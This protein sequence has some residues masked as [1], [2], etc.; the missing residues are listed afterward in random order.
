MA[1]NRNRTIYSAAAVYAGPT[2]ATGAHFTSG[3]SGVNLI[4]QIPRIQTFSLNADV[5]RQDVNQFGQLENIDQIIVEPPTVGANFSWLLTDGSS[6]SILGFAIKGN[7]TFISGQLDKTQDEKNYFVLIASEGNDAIGNTS[8]G[9]QNVI[10]IGN[11]FLSNY[12]VDLAVGQLPTATLSLEALNIKVDTG[13]NNTNNIPAVNPLNGQAVTGYTYLLPT[14]IAYTGTNIPSALR[15]GD[16][17]LELSPNAAIGN[18]LSGDGS[19][20]VQS[21]NFSVPL[22]REVLNRLGT[23]FAFSR[24]IQVPIVSTMTVNALMADLRASAL[25]NLLCNDALYNFRVKA[26]LPDCAGTGANSIIFD[27]KGA[28]LQ[29]QDFNLDLGGAG[30]TT[31]TFQTQLAGVSNST[32]KGFYFSGTYTG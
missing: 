3:N 29:S 2:P 28:K 14:A 30:S 17:V 26:K 9:T 15:P 24:E 32:V 7:T 21:I 31:M 8:T 18:I 22:S 23:P 16:L 13:N 11:G 4:K 5:P 1:Q 27:F 25:S 12:S 6:E 10:A 20:H 19:V